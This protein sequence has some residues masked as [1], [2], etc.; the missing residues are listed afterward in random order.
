MIDNLTGGPAMPEAGAGNVTFHAEATDN[1][2]GVARDPPWGFGAGISV[3]GTLL[4]CPDT[5]SFR[6]PL[7]VMSVEPGFGGQRF[8]S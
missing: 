5:A 7:L 3:A 8:G 2:V 6:H 1:L 4:I